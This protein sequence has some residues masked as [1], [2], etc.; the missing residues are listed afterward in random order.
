MI[1]YDNFGGFIEWTCVWGKEKTYSY[2]TPFSGIID[3]IPVQTHSYVIKNSDGSETEFSEGDL[4]DKYGHTNIKYKDGFENLASYSM[5]IRRFYLPQVYNVI[6]KHLE[7]Y[8][9]VGN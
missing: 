5:W 8:R 2:A 7:E 1:D 4:E 9:S 3:G 6:S